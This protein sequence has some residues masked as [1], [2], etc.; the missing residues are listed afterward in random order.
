MLSNQS[1]P[2]LLLNV[3]QNGKQ[4]NK[5]HLKVLQP[6]LFRIPRQIVIFSVLY[7]SLGNKQRVLMEVNQCHNVI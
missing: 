6:Q 7:E 1:Y 2:F 3:F 4:T 5:K